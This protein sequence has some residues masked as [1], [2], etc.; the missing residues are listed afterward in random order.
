MSAFMDIVAE[1]E[2]QIDVKGW[3]PEHDDEHVNGELAAAALCYC[4]AAQAMLGKPS[5]DPRIIMHPPFWPWADEWWKPSDVRRN[6]VKASAL[7]VA[8][9]ERL[10]R[11]SEREEQS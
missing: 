6:L 11:L 8:E 1:R 2:R 4:W 10:D 5:F 3:A 9:I 7:I